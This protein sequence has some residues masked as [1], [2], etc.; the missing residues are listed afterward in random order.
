MMQVR[1]RLSSESFLSPLQEQHP[2]LG[3]PRSTEQITTTLSLPDVLLVLI[4]LKMFA[5]L[6]A[7]SMICVEFLPNLIPK[8]IRLHFSPPF[9]TKCGT[10]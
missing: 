8:T 1:V 3:G 10:L 4:Q 9:T 2:E 6:K 5:F 7:V